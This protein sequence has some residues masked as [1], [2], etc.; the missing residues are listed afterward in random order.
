[1]YKER[2]EF[3]DLLFDLVLHVKVH[4]SYYQQFDILPMFMY[5]EPTGKGS[6]VP[7]S[8]EANSLIFISTRIYIHRIYFIFVTS[9]L[10]E[11]LHEDLH[12]SMMQVIS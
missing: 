11:E 2:G 9:S 8:T 1:M 3:W 7:L 5:P 4:R 10:V 6:K 12:P